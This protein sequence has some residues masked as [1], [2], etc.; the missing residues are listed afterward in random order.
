MVKNSPLGSSL[1]LVSPSPDLRAGCILFSVHSA[2]AKSLKPKSDSFALCS[3]CLTL[4]SIQA[5]LRWSMAKSAGLCILRTRAVLA[6]SCALT[7]GTQYI[8]QFKTC[9]ENPLAP[10]LKEVET[11]SHPILQFPL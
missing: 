6:L 10:S 2:G 9:T 8:L 4:L 11:V 3:A 1:M 5:L 7:A